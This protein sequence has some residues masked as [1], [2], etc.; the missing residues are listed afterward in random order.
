MFSTD[1]L[2]LLVERDVKAVVVACNT[3]TAVALADFRRRYDL[4]ILGV[5]R[6]GAAAASL[7]SR[8]RRVGVIATPA[9]VRSHAYFWAIKEEIQRSRCTNMQR[10][11]SSRWSRPVS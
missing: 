9:T 2:D 3:S 8:N 1:C 5:I 7:A 11:H 4:P 10:R 6:P